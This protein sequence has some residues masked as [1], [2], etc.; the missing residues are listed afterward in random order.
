MNVKPV[1][2][3]FDRDKILKAYPKNYKWF[4]INLKK[5]QFLLS[6]QVE[7]PRY[8]RQI[9]ELGLTFQYKR[10]TAHKGT[11]IP[12]MIRW[13]DFLF[14]CARNH[15][16]ST[17]NSKQDIKEGDEPRVSQ[18][19]APPWLFSY[20]EDVPCRRTPWK[21]FVSCKVQQMSELFQNVQNFWKKQ[22]KQTNLSFSISYFLLLLF[23]LYFSNY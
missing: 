19:T 4:A 15:S 20:N 12:T 23:P 1:G 16:S 22:E 10:W 9:H 17:R 2:T 3:P 11:N 8:K 7:S 18:H 21:I 13:Q 5:K 6:T 14:S